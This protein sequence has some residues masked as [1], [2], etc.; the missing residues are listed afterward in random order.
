MS[1]KTIMKNRKQTNFNGNEVPGTRDVGILRHGKTVSPLEQHTR[2]L[3]DKLF[4]IS[5]GKVFQW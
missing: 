3:G 4:E 2:V 1:M 5:V